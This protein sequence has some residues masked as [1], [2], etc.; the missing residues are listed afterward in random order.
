MK[1]QETNPSVN[2]ND[3]HD[4]PAVNYTADSLV[5]QKILAEIWGVGRQTAVKM[6]AELEASGLK[7][8][9]AGRG[10][11]RYRF[12]DVQKHL[13]EIKQPA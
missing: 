10:H 3:L 1:D 2:G 12:G 6:I 13:D 7:H 11:K 8:I 9:R 5:N 4:K